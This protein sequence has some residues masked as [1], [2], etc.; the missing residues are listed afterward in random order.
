M[1]LLIQEGK[2]CRIFFAAQTIRE[3]KHE[4]VEDIIDALALVGPVPDCSAGLLDFLKKET[5]SKKREI[6]LLA[7]E[8]SFKLPAVQK[9]ISDY[10]EQFKFV[11]C[12]VTS[13]LFMAF[14]T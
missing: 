13:H 8:D 10:R 12:F 4:K 2:R 3:L 6:F 1:S 7:A 11:I 14:Q 5:G 9:T